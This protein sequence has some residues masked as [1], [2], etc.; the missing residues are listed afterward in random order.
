M[1]YAQHYTPEDLL[2]IHIFGEYAMRIADITFKPLS[3]IT[4]ADLPFIRQMPVPP[5]GIII[6]GMKNDCKRFGKLEVTTEMK[7]NIVRFA[8]ENVKEYFQK[9][10]QNLN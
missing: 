7:N 4:I 5:N 10:N 9:E 1:N 3:E 2:L 6:Y 8:K